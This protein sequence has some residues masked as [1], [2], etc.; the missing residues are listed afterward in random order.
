MEI[1][2]LI[3]CY[4]GVVAEVKAC[5]GLAIRL[6]VTYLHAMYGFKDDEVD[7]VVVLHR[8]R[9]GANLH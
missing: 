8:V 4:R 6:Q 1:A 7:V 5:S 2:V 3:Y 9:L